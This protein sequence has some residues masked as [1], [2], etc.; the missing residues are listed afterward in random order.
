MAGWRHALLLCGL[1]LTLGACAG[2][3]GPGSKPLPGTPASSGSFKVG[4]P[5]KIDSTWYYPA[6]DWN[7]DETGIASWY[8]PDFHGKATANGEPYDMNGL[9]AAHRT[10]PIPSIVQVTNLDNGR[11][12]QLRIN[13]RGPYVRNRILDVSRRAAQLLGFIG[14]G[15]AKVRVK[16]LKDESMR[17]ANEAGAHFD[18]AETIVEA[19]VEAAEPLEALPATPVSVETL[20]PPPDAKAA[21][22]EQSIDQARTTNVALEVKP[23]PGKVV[24]LPV[25]PSHIYI[26]AG[27]FSKAENAERLKA[28]L[29]G[30][31]HVNVVGAKVKSIE[32][33]RVR[34]GP[35]DNVQDADQMLNRV[36]G[37]GANG[38][39]IVVD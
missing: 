38:A 4:N 36:V 17:A 25:A 14:P 22:A 23:P 12:I 37:K 3:S 8:G 28:Q 21:A 11:S 10:L 32:I 39:R 26:Q 35:I 15:T 13:D 9:T 29:G 7:Y 19:K 20:P 5:Y 16:I 30:L 2:E 31:G 18:I 27:A 34:V 24:V 33:Y 1:C 6:V